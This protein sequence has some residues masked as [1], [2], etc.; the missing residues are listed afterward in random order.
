MILGI[1][2]ILI[3]VKDLDKA[4]LVG[5]ALL[6]ADDPGAKVRELLGHREDQT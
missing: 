1:D 3:A 6:Q 2:H 5:E 4:M